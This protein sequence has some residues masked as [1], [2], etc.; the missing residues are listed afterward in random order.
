MDDTTT[1][2]DTATDEVDSADIDAQIKALQVKKVNAEKAKAAARRDARAA[3]EKPE[4]PEGQG[5]FDGEVKDGFRWERSSNSWR[6][7]VGVDLTE[8]PERLPYGFETVGDG[9]DASPHRVQQVQ[10]WM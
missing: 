3:G 2:D 9:S 7:H 6:E 4:P 8:N 1:R 10:R 5:K